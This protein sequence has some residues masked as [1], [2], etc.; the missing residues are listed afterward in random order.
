MKKILL[1]VIAA[2]TLQFSAA[3]GIYQFADPGF[4]QYTTSGNEPGNGWN[5]F[6]SAT[7]SMASLG[8]GS[9][10]KPQHVTPG[11]NG[12]SHAVQIFSKSILGKK[13]NGNLTTGM[14]NMGSMTPADAANYNYTKRDDSSHSLLFA[15]RPDAVSFWAKFVSGG[16]PNG[17]GQFILHDGDVDY[18]D[19]EVADQLANRIG[20]ASALIPASSDWVQYTAEFTYDKAQTATQ[21]LLASFTT[22][23]TP[24]GSANDY[25]S[26][27]EVYFIYYHALS[28]LSYDGAALDLEEAATATGC[29]LAPA[30]Y[31]PALLGYV[32]KGAGATAEVD[33]TALTGTVTITV[34]GDDFSVNADS[35]TIYTLFFAPETVDPEPEPDP[36]PEPDPEPGV[37]ALGESIQDLSQLSNEKTYVLYNPTYTAFAISNPEYSAT[38]VWT[39]NMIDG[40]ATHR[41]VDASYSL[42]LDT[43][44][45]HTAWMI[46]PFDGKYY[47]YNMGAKKFLVTPGQD[48]NPAICRFTDTV[49]G[50]AIESLG[51]G[52]FALNT[53][54]T[55]R[56][57]MCAAPQLAYPVSIWTSSDSGSCWEIK[58]NPNVL[59][60]AEVLGLIDPS[61]VPDPGPDPEP[62]PEPDPEPQPAALG[63]PILSLAELSNDS[64][65][66]VYNPSFTTF[67]TYH[68]THSNP[69][70][71]IW[72]AGMIGDSEHPVA[73]NAYKTALDST[74]VNGAW[75]V[76]S[77]GE[78]LYIYNMGAGK[79]LSTPGYVDATSACLFS[80]EP[81]ALTVEQLGESTFALTATGHEKDYLCVAPQSYYY[82][83]SIWEKTDAGACWQ[84]LPNRTVEADPA[85]VDQILT[86][87]A[88]HEANV[89]PAGRPGVYSLGG[90]YLGTDTKHLGKG[91]YI[92]GGR[93]VVVK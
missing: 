93:K 22:N 81:V 43:A 62:E 79:Y 76:I 86:A 57:Y 18:R 5:S 44:S 25:L 34:K 8:K 32:V 33:Y 37:K 61:L 1:S 83:V 19:P 39:A 64:T 88:I 65:Y 14:I 89:Q 56:A 27:D 55:S 38:N 17:R 31:D 80:E 58:E 15:G 91:V 60:D 21:Y 69:E 16:S 12:T 87:T 4:E 70:G 36:D 73:Q 3:Q 51:G 54:G 47:V 50:L 41:V 42:P 11:A 10:P 90:V 13:A 23:P 45:A 20:I 67:I 68:A 6:N 30:T 2:C 75:M 7:G 59:A 35:K 48:E 24:G 78:H 40:D 52:R 29:N 92:V 66:A 82:P 84:F 71:Y 49:S 46:V 28:A 72:A 77:V 63:M 85:V 9:S 74:S 26:V 53:T